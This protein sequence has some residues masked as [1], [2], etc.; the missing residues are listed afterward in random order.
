MN[1]PFDPSGAISWL[2]PVSKAG[3]YV[4]LRAEMDAFV[5]MS[6]CPQDLVPVNGA[7]MVPADL[8]FTVM[9]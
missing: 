5:V 4:V 2:S 8:D 1:T 9:E 7:N 6:A 3:D